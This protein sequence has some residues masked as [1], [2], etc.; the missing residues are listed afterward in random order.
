VK[1]SLP[2]TRRGRVIAVV[3]FLLLIAAVAG[4]ALRP[5]KTPALATSPVVRANLEQTVEATGS[6][7]AFKLVSVGAQASGQIKALKVQLGDKVKTGD[8]IAEIDS[9]TQINS[10]R[11]AESALDSIR[12]QRAQQVAVRTEAELTYARQQQM[13][14]AEATSRA[15]YEAAEATL[16]SA[17]AQIQVLDAQIKQQQTQLDTAKANLGYTRITA[18]IDGT[19]VA[20]IAEEGQTVNASQST[21]TIVKL[22]KLDVVTVNAEISEADVVKVKPD[23]PVYFTILGDPDT[24]YRAKLR[25]I[26][27]APSSI[28]TETSS[29]GSAASSSST[30]SSSAIYYNALFD[31]ENP[32]GVLRISMTAQVSV[33]LGQVHD[34]LI[35]PSAALGPRVPDREPNKEPS[36]NKA[37]GATYTVQVLGKDGWPETR[38]IVVGLNNNANAEVKSGLTEGER[39]V[40]GEASAATATST[41]QRRGGPM[42]MGRP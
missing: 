33:V 20:V 28:E 38:Q 31:V 12:A 32:D 15:D 14:S 7:E 1:F 16:A 6:I 21:P 2:N 17:R 4:W 39:V 29:A 8:L 37:G 27:P 10:L 30:S 11:N 40:V 41:A 42:M 22:A 25:T 36:E 23:L 35:I 19:V 24:K 26:E 34:A 13:L 3:I 18:P 9:T 5:A